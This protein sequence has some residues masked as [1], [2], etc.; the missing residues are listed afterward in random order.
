MIPKSSDDRKLYHLSISV[1]SIRGIVF[2]AIL[3]LS[4]LLQASVYLPITELSRS[5]VSGIESSTGI[6]I[7]ICC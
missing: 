2:Q 7:P 3:S 1:A 5:E 4:G 6:T